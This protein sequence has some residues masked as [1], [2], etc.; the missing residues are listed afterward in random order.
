M[1]KTVAKFRRIEA[2][3]VEH[4]VST[5][6]GVRGS[7]ARDRKN[8]RCVI[9]DILVRKESAVLQDVADLSPK[10]YR[11]PFRCRL[12][13]DDHLPRGRFEKTVYQSMS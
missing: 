11:I 5:C 7:N 8:H 2:Y 6:G 13:L 12:S 1:R 4:L 10:G 3:E 9:A